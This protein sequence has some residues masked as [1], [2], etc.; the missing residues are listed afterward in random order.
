MNKGFDTL[1]F[2]LIQDDLPKGRKGYFL[3]VVKD[4]RLFAVGCFKKGV[5]SEK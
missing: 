3:Q 1:H 4:V 2:V 5:L